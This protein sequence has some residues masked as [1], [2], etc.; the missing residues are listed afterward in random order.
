MK[1]K[2]LVRELRRKLRKDEE[3][4]A[5]R[6]KLAASYRES[7]RGEEAVELYLDVALDYRK[8]GRI[9][10]AI[11]VCRSALDIDPSDDEVKNLLANLEQ[12]READPPVRRARGGAGARGDEAVVEDDGRNWTPSLA[13]AATGRS[14]HKSGDGAGREAGDSRESDASAAARADQPTG[15]AAGQ[16][17]GRSEAAA[18]DRRSEPT[19]GAASGAVPGAAADAASGRAPRA[20]GASAAAHP[21]DDPDA[22]PDDTSLT[23][24]P[25]P[26]PLPP[27]EADDD[28]MELSHLLVRPAPAGPLPRISLP[29]DLAEVDDDLLDLPPPADM[30]DVLADVFLPTAHFDPDGEADTQL[31]TAPGGVPVAEDEFRDDTLAPQVES[32]A[33]ARHRSSPGDEEMTWL[34]EPLSRAPSEPEPVLFAGGEDGRFM[35]DALP[36]ALETA[37]GEQEPTQWN[38]PGAGGAG[39]ES[40]EATV[41]R[42]TTL[43][44]LGGADVGE[45]RGHGAGAGA[46]DVAPDADLAALAAGAPLGQGEH[47][48]D[49]SAG[50]TARLVAVSAPA[51][52]PRSAAEAAPEMIVDE[53]RDKTM[54]QAIPGVFLPGV[55]AASPHAS[56][57]SLS[58]MLRAAFDTLPGEVLGDLSARAMLRSVGASEYVFREGDPGDACFL[59][60]AGELRA[61][62]RDPFVPGEPS[63]EVSRWGA[64]AL[65]GELALLAD[66]RRHASVQAVGA[67]RIY[68]IPRRLLRELA[69]TY[70]EVGG[71]LDALYRQR[72]LTMLVGTAP[73]L[74]TLPGQRRLEIQRRFQ[75]I[76]RSSGEAIVR[77]GSADGGLYLVVQ[78]SVEITKRGSDKRST[79]LATF[80]EGAYFGNMSSV[81]GRDAGASVTA[82]GPVE[83]AVLPSEEFQD[84]V[85]EG[86]G[87]WAQIRQTARRRDLESNGL[88]TGETPIV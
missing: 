25:L 78:G 63:V 20:P 51:L 4:P 14:P 67:C 18:A 47:G 73:F 84:V 55:P 11:A 22:S 75:S 57:G 37:E 77:E 24:T 88:L 1:I 76:H 86:P 10:Q 58:S 85:A 12:M 50:R 31:G 79:L 66:R 54:R 64:G 82:A 36:M 61:L 81:E 44:G 33:T 5:A 42:S 80:V 6:L 30:V 43:P 2:R 9:A 15:Q 3:S 16:P 17:A 7:G 72:L 49:A 21:E 60:D 52:E 35:P 56:G 69:A 62:R 48:D 83:L 71:L 87:I 65:F 29:R 46:G 32:G 59:V 70:P 19:P 13:R 34:K 40:P 53:E 8:L 45:A 41:V 68:E 74:N 26:T 39:L 38:V 23:P 28:S 27:H